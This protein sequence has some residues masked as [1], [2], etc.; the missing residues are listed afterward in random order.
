MDHDTTLQNNLHERISIVIKLGYIGLKNYDL[1]GASKDSVTT[2][3]TIA[4]SKTNYSLYMKW[5][6]LEIKVAARETWK[7]N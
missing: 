3:E 1:I 6:T 4:V 2:K 5:Y 7:L